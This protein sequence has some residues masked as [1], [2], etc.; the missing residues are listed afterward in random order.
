MPNAL[1]DALF[2]PHQGSTRPF[3]Y[4]PDGTVLS[5]DAFLKLTAQIAHV[6]QE[7]GVR[8]GDRVAA[9]VKKSAK[10]LALYAACI[11][12]GA[13][14]L[15]LNTAYT[16]SE[17]E[18]FVGNAEPRLVVCDRASEEAL[19][20]IVEKAD[21]RL[22]TLDGDPT[23]LSPSRG[24]ATTSPPSSTLPARPGVPRARC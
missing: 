11:Q 16:P 14:F 18:Y 9:Q 15:P 3:L 24:P 22:L 5:Y 17:V 2:A 13:V 6:L 1:Y 20:P 12:A 7:E 19:A 4:L 8:P 10:A 21:A 23:A